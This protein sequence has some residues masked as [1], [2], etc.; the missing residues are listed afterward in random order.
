MEANTTARCVKRVL[1]G[2]RDHRCGIGCRPRDRRPRRVSGT[3]GDERRQGQGHKLYERDLGAAAS[4]ATAV[5]GSGPELEGQ[6]TT[7]TPFAPWG[8]WPRTAG[9]NPQLTPVLEQG[10][11]RGARRPR[12]GADSAGVAGGAFWGRELPVRVAFFPQRVE[13]ESACGVDKCLGCLWS[14]GEASAVS[15]RTARRATGPGSKRA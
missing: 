13:G 2:W 1:R 7:A 15:G 9:K 8:A 6:V 14:P 3:P 12:K 4:R 11:R 10:Q 5:S